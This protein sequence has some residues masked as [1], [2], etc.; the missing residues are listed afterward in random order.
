MEHLEDGMTLPLYFIYLFYLRELHT[1]ITTI[2]A[3]GLS[4]SDVNGFNVSVEMEKT[5]DRFVKVCF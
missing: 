1:L 3:S 4:W 2:K 5:F